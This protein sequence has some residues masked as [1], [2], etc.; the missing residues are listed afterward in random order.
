MNQKFSHAI[1]ISVVLFA[2]SSIAQEGLPIRGPDYFRDASDLATVLGS[3]HGVRVTCNGESDQYWRKYMA[4]MLGF[5]APNRGSL[6]TGLVQNFNQAY[7]SARE[8]YPHCNGRAVEAEARFAKDGKNIA[9]RMAQHY[10][11][12]PQ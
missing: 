8:D 7:I 11:P 9:S 4:D 1:L 2:G 10:F 5:E 6:R 3:A 12:K